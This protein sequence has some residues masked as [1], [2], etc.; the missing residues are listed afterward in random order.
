[1]DIAQHIRI[2]DKM[3]TDELLEKRTTAINSLAEKYQG[4]ASVENLLQLAADFT[5]GVAKGGS[6]PEPRIAEIEAAIR[7]TSGSFVREGQEVQLLTC[8]LLA[9]LK[10][11]TEATP[12][13]AEWSRR[14]VVALGLWSGLGYQIPRTEE[15]LEGLRSELLVAAR[16]LVL[17]SSA[18]AR[19]RQDVPAITAKMPEAYDATKVGSAVQNG[20]ARAIDALRTNAALD[21]E[22]IDLL[23]W[24]L[25]GWS[26]FA[27]KIFSNMSESAAVVVA[28]LEAGSIVRRI[29]GEAHKHL[30]LRLLTHDKTVSMQDMLESLKEE[31]EKIA[32]V[33]A[34]NPLL[35]GRESLFPLVSAFVA[36]KAE[37]K[38]GG[39]RALKVSD[40]AARALLESSILH[41]GQL[42]RNLV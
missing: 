16:N 18:N 35:A 26:K 25:S 32:V 38:G 41:V 40:W 3:P 22:E 39:T 11:L 20:G 21:R 27:E 19:K 13:S 33:F 5:K 28:G 23:W 4:V 42:P 9:A 1:M 10:L 36:G 31:R 12:S 14:D 6:L 37:G 29:P 7:E 17:G 24:V 30:I 15:R 34:N 8:G 2:F